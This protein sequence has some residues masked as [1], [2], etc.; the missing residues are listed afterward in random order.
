VEVYNGHA[1][2]QIARKSDLRENRQSTKLRHSWART[3]MTALGAN[4]EAAEVKY[5]R[6][7]SAS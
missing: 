2:S 4:P 3:W 5:H 6:L 7:L 1:M